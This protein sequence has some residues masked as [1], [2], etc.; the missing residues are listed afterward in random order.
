MARP[1][2]KLSEA[3]TCGLCLDS[4]VAVVIWQVEDLIVNCP[5]WSLKGLRQSKRKTDS[6]W[7]TIRWESS[8]TREYLTG[9]QREDTSLKVIIQFKEASAVRPK[10]E[11][12]SPYDRPVKTLFAQWDQLEFR[13]Q[14][15]C[16]RWEEESGSR[17]KCEIILPWELARDGTKSTPWAYYCVSPGC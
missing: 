6:K 8:W 5:R 11:D 12:V 9:L 1:R 14:V 16:W 15:L 10:L 2:H 4:W 7:N 3:Q 17:T 13:V